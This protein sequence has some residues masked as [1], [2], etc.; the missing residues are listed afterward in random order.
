MNG[1][2]LSVLLDYYVVVG[3]SGDGIYTL[4]SSGERGQRSYIDMF[5]IAAC[6]RFCMVLV[7]PRFINRVQNP[8]VLP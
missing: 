5:R 7:V 8:Q 4:D 2:F 1:L 6:F 3:I